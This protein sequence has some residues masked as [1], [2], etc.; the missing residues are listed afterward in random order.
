MQSGFGALIL[1]PLIA[2]WCLMTAAA[3]VFPLLAV[4]PSTRRPSYPL[5]AIWGIVAA[6]IAVGAIVL[7]QST[8][9]VPTGVVVQ[10]PSPFLQLREM[11][12]VEVL[13]GCGVA[14]AASGLLYAH[15]ARRRMTG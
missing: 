10:G 12:R 11:T 1:A 8:S 6:W 2:F 15:A 13:V 5:A 9:F 7:G 4:W 14:G 3:F